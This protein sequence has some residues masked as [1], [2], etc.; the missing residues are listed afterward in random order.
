[1]ASA[2]TLLRATDGVEDTRALAAQVATVLR[3][4]DVVALAGDLGSGKT[5]FVQ[6]AARGL[7][8]R[9]P[10]VSP[11]FT[12]VREYHGRMTVEHLDV[13]RLDREQEVL[14]LDLDDLVEGGGV[15]FV[16]WGDAIEGLL[17][18]HLSVRIG[19]PDGDLESD[20]RTFRFDA[21][22][23]AWAQRW[24]RLAAAT[25]RWSPRP[26]GGAHGGVGRA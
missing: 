8:V 19:F 11:T 22:G 26:G 5:A 17:P 21:A 15:V 9:E 14:D 1:V 24:E 2:S 25:R 12:L 18:G 6:G 4:G 3:P 10:V 20:R 23:S 16:E 13:Y 7:D